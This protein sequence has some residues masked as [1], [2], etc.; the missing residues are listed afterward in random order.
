MLLKLFALP[1]LYRLG[2]IDRAALYETNILQLLHHQPIERDT[3]LAALTPHMLPSD[4]NAL[5]EVLKDIASLLV[6][7]TRF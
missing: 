5:R 7:A 4:I 1:S 3:L 6:H 2:N